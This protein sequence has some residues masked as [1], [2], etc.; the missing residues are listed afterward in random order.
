MAH[1]PASLSKSKENPD[2]VNFEEIARGHN[3]G[4]VCRMFLACLQLANMGNLSMM[5]DTK[6]LEGC[7]LVSSAATITLAS[8]KGGGRAARHTAAASSLATD[9]GLGKTAKCF[10]PTSGAPFE[11]FS[12]RLVN[13]TRRLDVENFRTHAVFL[14]AH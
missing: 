6:T 2:V 11:I 1:K 3:S 5:P 13:D 12:V 7:S 14:E 8:K 4:E 9:D 10:G